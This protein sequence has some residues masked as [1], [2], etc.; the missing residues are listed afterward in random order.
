M[1]PEPLN[2]AAFWQAFQFGVFGHLVLLAMTAVQFWFM[3]SLMKREC[4]LVE[5]TQER[6]KVRVAQ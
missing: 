1:T 5:Q 4:E 2:L 6:E 3:R